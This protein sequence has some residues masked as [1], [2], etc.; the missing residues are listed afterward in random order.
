MITSSV[1]VYNTDR[2]E[3]A[4]LLHSVAQSCVEHLYVVDNSPT[5]ALKEFVLQ[6]HPNAEYIYGQGNIGYGAAHNIAIRKA[7]GTGAKYHVLLNPDIRFDRETIEKLAGYADQN[8]D[9]GQIMPKIV[10]PN[11]KIQYLCKLLP[12]PMDLIGR[13][14]LPCKS[15]VEK[16][17]SR[18]EMHSTSYDKTIEVPFL[19]GC[20]MFLRVDALR[21]VGGFDDRFFMYCED[22][23]L[24]RRIGM[25]G[26]RT[27]YLPEATAVHAHRKESFKS[28]TML[29]AHVRSAI[30]YF[31]KWGW[32]FDTYRN[33]TN[34]KAINQ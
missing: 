9:A 24:C 16:R 33:K 34:K 12:A 7:I 17:N 18:F 15:Y 1:V 4:A 3:L 27:I 29:R 10:Y 28:K 23:D 11:G 21:Q 32:I 30:R 25:A 2:D 20:F 5:D 26:Y 14:F 6:I 19:S 22:I 13:R 8:P 31:N